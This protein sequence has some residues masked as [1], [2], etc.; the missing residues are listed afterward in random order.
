MEYVLKFS[1]AFVLFICFKRCNYALRLR[2]SFI[3]NSFDILSKNL[4]NSN[5][6]FEDEI[7]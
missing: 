1:L 6:L 5:F 7:H 2:F 3:F 4:R